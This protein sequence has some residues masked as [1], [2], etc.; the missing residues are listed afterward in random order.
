MN[1]PINPLERVSPYA[2]RDGVLRTGDLADLLDFTLAH[3]VD[4]GLSKLGQAGLTPDY[5]SSRT[6][7]R[8]MLDAWRDRIEG[9]VTA[10]LPGLLAELGIKPFPVSRF[11]LELV[12][13]NDGDFYRTHIDTKMGP[14]EGRGTRLVSM[15]YYF[16]VEPKAFTGGA[17]RLFSLASKSVFAD[18]EPAQ[19]RLVAF[20]SWVPHEVRPTICPSGAFTDSRFSINCWAR[21]KGKTAPAQSQS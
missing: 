17:L 3:E 18:V 19:N 4:F 16:H 5:R 13:N 2:V 21:S 14:R 1:A 6:L 11:E 12:A 15:V 10:L 7:P 9:Y 20:P 8:R